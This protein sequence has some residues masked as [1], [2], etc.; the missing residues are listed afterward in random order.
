MQLGQRCPLGAQVALAPH[1]VRVAANADHA[2]AACLDAQTA[3]RLTQRAGAQMR[4][5]AVFRPSFHA[6]TLPDQRHLDKQLLVRSSL[7]PGGGEVR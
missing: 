1:V 7:A 2:I 5:S 4:S 3:H 6:D